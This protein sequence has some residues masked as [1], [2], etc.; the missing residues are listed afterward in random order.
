MVLLV[1]FLRD[2]FFIHD[3]LEGADMHWAFKSLPETD[4]QE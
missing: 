2:L 1:I 4:L 3:V